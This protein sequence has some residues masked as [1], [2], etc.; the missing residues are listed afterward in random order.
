MHN[1]I[2][3][4][5]FFNQ[6]L[7]KKKIS[8]A[9]MAKYFNWEEKLFADFVR[10]NDHL[11]NVLLAV[12]L[13]QTQ[14]TGPKN[15]F[16]KMQERFFKEHF[17][18][19]LLYDLLSVYENIDMAQA[20]SGWTE[21]YFFHVFNQLKEQQIISVLGEGKIEFSGGPFRE[22]IP[23][24]VL[25]N[26]F[27]DLAQK[28]VEDQ[29]WEFGMDSLKFSLLDAPEA[30]I[31]EVEKKLDLAVEEGEIEFLT[32]QLLMI[33]L[34]NASHLNSTIGSSKLAHP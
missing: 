6:Y 13:Y 33:L 28:E 10:Q 34:E 9:K 4:M 2:I 16:T 5:G 23:G 18:H 14:I 17:D 15:Y 25:E 12:R 32:V 11:K 24:G 8:L 7:K 21:D 26:N 31:P 29:A 19:L 30:V 22:F 3:P 27:Y 20:I 1:Q